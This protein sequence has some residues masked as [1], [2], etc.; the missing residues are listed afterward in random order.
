[1]IILL[2]LLFYHVPSIY[3]FLNN[4][5]NFS[6]KFS[7]EKDKLKYYKTA[8]VRASSPEAAKDKLVSSLIRINGNVY[9]GFAFEKI[10]VSSFNYIFV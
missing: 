2:N 6:I 10:S 3:L 1:M 4:M 9:A 5:P 7:F 8:I